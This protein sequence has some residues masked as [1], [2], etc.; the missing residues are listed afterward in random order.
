MNITAPIYLAPQ[1]ATTERGRISEQARRTQLI[2]LC[3]IQLWGAILLSRLAVP[4]GG[5][6]Q[7]QATWIFAFICFLIIGFRANW[8]VSGLRLAGLACLAVVIMFETFYIHHEYS[9]LS[10]LYLFGIYAPLCLTLPSLSRQDLPEIWASFIRLA[11]VLA[12]GGLVQVVLQFI[13]RG[14]FLDP[15]AL[16]PKMFQLSNYVTHYQ[17]SI[18]PIS[19]VKPNGLFALEPSFFSQFIGLGLIGEFVYFRRP[20]VVAL[21]IAALSISFAGTGVVVLLFGV[22]FLKQAPKWIFGI[23]LAGVVWSLAV[24]DAGRDFYARRLNEF[25]EPGTS[26]NARFVRP[27]QRVWETWQRSSRDAAFGIGAGQSGDQGAVYES[28]FPPLAK[29][30][31]E[32]GLFGLI[33]FGFYW[34]G[35]F[36][37]PAIPP[38]LKAS[39]VVLYFV[40]AGSLLHPPTVFPI[41]SLTLG[42]VSQSRRS[43]IS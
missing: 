2:R 27:Y 5:G 31:M 13:V 9:P 19:F 24:G 15:V 38:P 30:T 29:A 18:G 1:S 22:P 12:I 43:F 11:T 10:I 16:L 7:I 17:T 23:L 21:L 25:E 33:A 35:M 8:A 3:E 39:L 14:Y 32:F 40:A 6:K 34:T 36:F 41:W 26:G 4:F 42:F 37:K 28:S 20:K